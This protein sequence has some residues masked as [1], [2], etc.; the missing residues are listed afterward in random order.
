VLFKALTIVTHQWLLS[1]S[2]D[3]LDDALPRKLALSLQTLQAPG[4][5]SQKS[6]SPSMMKVPNLKEIFQQVENFSV[7]Q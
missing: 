2:N 7:S 1:F 6:V 4:I 5:S 3:N